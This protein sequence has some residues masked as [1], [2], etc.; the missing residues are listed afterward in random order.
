MLIAHVESGTSK[1]HVQFVINF[2]EFCCTC[3][4]S[5]QRKMYMYNFECTFFKI[6]CTTRCT[7]SHQR[8]GTYIYGLDAITLEEA[9]QIPQNSPSEGDFCA[10][11]SAL[12]K[13]KGLVYT[14]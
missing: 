7:V 14:V 10:S 5:V 4:A 12:V 13:G 1:V 8:K 11:G 9:R 6:R 3:T 2:R